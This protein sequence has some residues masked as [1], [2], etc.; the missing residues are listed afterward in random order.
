MQGV[1]GGANAYPFL[2]E[3]LQDH[4]VFFLPQTHFTPLILAP[5][6]EFS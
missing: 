5:K 1:S 3:L 2:S 6:S 4:A